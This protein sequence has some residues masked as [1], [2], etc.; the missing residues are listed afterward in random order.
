MNSSSSLKIFFI[1]IAVQVV[2]GYF[3]PLRQSYRFDLTTSIQQ[4][5]DK[6]V[7]ISSSKLTSID[8]QSIIP[9]RAINPDSIQASLVQSIGKLH[10]ELEPYWVQAYS[11]LR[12]QPYFAAPIVQITLIL[13]IVI[14]SSDKLFAKGQVTVRSEGGNGMMIYKSGT[15]NADDA[16]EYYTKRPL[17]VATR[18]LNILLTSAGF[19]LS[20]LS[21]YLTK[22][23]IDPKQEKLRAEKL[24]TLLTRLG[25]TFIKIGQSLSVRTDLLRP[26]YI[27]ALAQLQDKVPPFPTSE[28]RRLI[29]L[30]LGAPVDD[31]FI[32]ISDSSEV[33]A[34]AS[35]GQVYKA[36]LRSD[37]DQSY[38]AVKVQRPDIINSVSL[39]MHIIRK[40]APLIKE[41]ASLQSDLVGVVDDW[42]KGFVDELN[43]TKEAQN[44]RVFM[45]TISRTPLGTI[46]F[47][48][49]VISEASSLKVLTTK[50]V[51]GE[52]LEKCSKEESIRLCSVA[53]NTYLTMMLE[54]SIL[55]ADPHPGNLR[56]TPDGRL[57]I[58]DWGL[59]T[60]ISS[61]LQLNFID[62][63]A[64]LVSKD[65]EEVPGDLVKLGFVPLGKEDTIL[66]SGVVMVL[67]EIYSEFAKGGGASK[68]DVAGVVSKLNNLSSTYGNIFQLPPYFAY[69]ARAFGVLEGIGLA[70]DPNYAIVSECLP[71]IARRLLGN[72]DDRTSA[73]LTGF[74][75]GK[76]KGNVDTRII[77]VERIELLLNGV[78][79]YQKA[80]HSLD[81]ADGGLV[82]AL[83]NR[84]PTP[85]MDRDQLHAMRMK[86]VNDITDAIF[87]IL[88]GGGIEGEKEASTS[89]TPM[90]TLV[91]EEV[92]K[93]IGAVS[94]TQLSSLRS[95][96]IVFPNQ[97]SLIGTLV[98][99]LGLFRDSKLVLPDENDRLIIES[100]R[101]LLGILQSSDIIR[102]G[103]RQLLAD[104][105]FDEVREISLLLINKVWRR[106]RNVMML[107]RRLLG[108]VMRQMASRI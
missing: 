92:V 106:R 25:P 94:R 10:S 9:W 45:D 101:S 15:Y 84:N 23:L 26:A 78:T 13:F 6:I 48:P 80:A 42:G 74:I 49:T 41:A 1:L 99:P 21:D 60:S 55:H 62:H 69:I 59:V 4:W 38:V 97:R 7:S 30:E 46:V 11:L 91:L 98:D 52:R 53:M 50:W 35:L 29:E 5:E 8:I 61:D 31:I 28:A 19:G 2:D 12:D 17:L 66:S 83:D 108:T 102:P 103:V 65:Y 47:A 77:D 36:Q 58:M 22:K 85:I 40:L 105:S 70:S 88:L 71:Y 56:C 95:R 79:N 32:G 34:A 37:K 24:T 76:N 18:A 16:D 100:T 43:Y 14:A 104:L 87:V 81:T 82:L 63:I 54:S 20:L 96:S 75:F 33:V 39:D 3:D 44:A 51:D 93:I 67:A 27:I 57:C 86:Q 68:I 73:A 89:T 90:Q 107:N 72:S 64:H